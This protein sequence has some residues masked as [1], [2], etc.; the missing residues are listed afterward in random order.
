MRAILQCCAS[1]GVVI[2][3]QQEEKIGRGFVILLGITHTDTMR[4]VE[5][6][7][8]KCVALRVFPDSEDKLNC[9]LGDIDGEVLVISNFTLY[10]D[11]KKGRRPSYTNAARPEQAIPLY[12][13]FIERLRAGGI[14][15]VATGKF[16][17]DML[18]SI[19]NDGPVTI[20][21][22]SDELK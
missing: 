3:R 1:G 4:E 14:K 9:S 10:A 13:A 12:E 18:V 7:A 22:D 20:I 6:V 16:G 5:L 17:A 19:Q 2:D 11:A 21:L 15:R 8:D